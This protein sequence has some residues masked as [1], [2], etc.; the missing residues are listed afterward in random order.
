MT[1]LHREETARGPQCNQH[2]VEDVSDKTYEL[3]SIPTGIMPAFHDVSKTTHKS[4]DSSSTTEI[5]ILDL[6]PFMHVLP[7]GTKE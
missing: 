5:L 1:S 6:R 7:V 4:L 3:T 2:S